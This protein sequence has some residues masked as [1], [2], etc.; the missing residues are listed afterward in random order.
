MANFAK[1]NENNVVDQVIVMNDT[2]ATSQLSGLEFIKSLPGIEG[3]WK[4]CSDNVSIGFTYNIELECFVPPKPYTS[5]VLNTQTT[6]W[7]S[8]VE[9][10]INTG[11][12]YWSWDEE[13]V[14][15]KKTDIEKPFPSWEANEELLRW[16]PPT[17]R[18]EF[19]EADP[20]YYRWDESTLSWVEVDA[21]VIPDA[22]QLPT[23]PTR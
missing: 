2:D 8:P 13:T 18:P 21:P 4:E 16:V 17:P 3:N 1:L 9:K 14:S 6:Q 19:N 12:T 20:K 11:F 10:P 22:P 23:R 15:W 7:E 5:W